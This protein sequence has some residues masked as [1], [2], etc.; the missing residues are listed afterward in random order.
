MMNPYT[1][2]KIKHLGRSLHR[3]QSNP[4]ERV[5]SEEWSKQARSGHTLEWLLCASADQQVQL[6][7][8][9]QRE[10]TCAATLMQWL[11]SPV[12]FCWLEETMKKAKV[13]K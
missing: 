9:T 5:F 6:R 2:P 1:P 10:A 13:A 8:I 4:V 3:I 12:G 7:N 11:G